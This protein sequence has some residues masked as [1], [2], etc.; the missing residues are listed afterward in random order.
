MH[1]LAVLQRLH[2]SEINWHIIAFFDG[3]IIAALGHSVNDA[4]WS[5]TFPTVQQAVDGLVSAALEH[6]PES[7]FAA[8]YHG[9]GV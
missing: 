3:A 2:D 1:T 5:E 6:Y 8:D 9:I 7:K 4:L